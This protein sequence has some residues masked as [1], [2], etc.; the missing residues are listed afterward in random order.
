MCF[1]IDVDNVNIHHGVH[2]QV[3]H[4]VPHYRRLGKLEW[5]HCGGQRN[6]LQKISLSFFEKSSSGQWIFDKS[7]SGKVH[8]AMAEDGGHGDGGIGRPTEAEHCHHH[9]H[10]GCQ[11]LALASAKVLAKL[12]NES[13]ILYISSFK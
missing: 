2:D 8:L 13:G 6:A 10:L 4:W 11:S 3:Y 1:D 9:D 5:Q 12:T 7:L